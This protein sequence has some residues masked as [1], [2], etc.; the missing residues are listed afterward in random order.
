MVDLLPERAGVSTGVE[1]VPAPKRKGRIGAAMLG[2]LQASPPIERPVAFAL[3]FAIG[4]A[5]YFA[6]THEPSWTFVGW[7]VAA[8][9]L[10]WLGLRAVWQVPTL[11]LFGLIGFG[12]SLG[13]AS[14]KLRTHVAGG[15][16]IEEGLDP[17]LVEGWVAAIDRGG[18]GPRLTLDVHAISGLSPDQTPRQVRMT[19]RLDLNVAPGRFVRCYGVLRPPP[20]PSMAGDYNFRREAWFRGLGGVGYVQGRCRGGTLG[21]PG[22]F[23]RGLQTDV[24]SVRRQF[25]EY[26]NT[27]A[28]QRAGGFAAALMAGDRSF[29]SQADADALRGAGLAHILA[30]S[31][32]HMGIVGGLVYLIVRRGLALVEPLALRIPVQKPAA[33]TALIASASYLIISGASVS[34][35]RAFIMA[36]IFFG[37]ILFDRAALSLRSFALAMIAVVA[38]HPESV[39]SPGF[40]MSFAAT[41]ALIAT[42]GAWSERRRANPDKAGGMGF[43]FTVKSLFVT[44]F[45]GAVA[46]APF[47]LFHFG[48]VAALGLA[49]NLL[50]MPVISFASAPLAAGSLL[51]VPFGLSE[52][53]IGLFGRS[54]EAVLWVAH[55]FDRGS[56][57]WMQAM[58][59]LP[60]LALWGFVAALIGL[61]VARGAFRWFVIGFCTVLG[62]WAWIEAPRVLLHWAPSGDVYVMSDEGHQRIAFVEADGLGPLRYSGLEVARDCSDQGCTI[63]TPAGRIVL[64]TSGPGASTC[65]DLGDGI[66]LFAEGN[67]VWCDGHFTWDRTTQDGPLTL[68]RARSGEW[69]GRTV[70][71]CTNR[72]WA[73]CALPD[74]S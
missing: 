51:A 9:L 55:T 5:I 4:A 73:R 26:V 46:T 38:L 3:S 72:P 48:R 65:G 12:L 2:W 56:P 8:G 54:L 41:G 19:H 63:D 27:A 29:M 21:R 34:T 71:V 13:V 20:A 66:H 45:V 47:A 37:A 28:G 44:S 61:V 17:V 53:M 32:L 35:Q 33:A 1:H 36:A 62:A 16:V 11:A 74:Q 40:Q 70:S 59:Q 67:E 50:A 22:G 7:L 49:A 68:W 64:H 23:L 58:P 69:W 24:A 31:G 14:G 15:P 25:A 30:I 39:M 57:D 42:Y 18:S 6:L 52:A 60:P 10:G 43:S